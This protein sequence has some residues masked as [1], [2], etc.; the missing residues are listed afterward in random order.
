MSKQVDQLKELANEDRN[1][2]EIGFAEAII[3]GENILVTASKWGANKPGKKEYVR[4]SV[5]NKGVA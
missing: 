1:G 4:Y 5:T 2:G 3:N